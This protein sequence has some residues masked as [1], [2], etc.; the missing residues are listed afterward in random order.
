MHFKPLTLLIFAQ[1][2]LTTSAIFQPE[3]FVSK[4]GKLDVTLEV[5][6][7]TSVNGTRIAPGY[8]GNAMG[9]TIRV[10]P[11]DLVSITLKNNLEPSTS[12]ERE[13]LDYVY[14][15][16]S[17]ILDELN[18]TIAY[19]RLS[20]EGYDGGQPKYGF[21]GKNYMNLHFHGANVDPKIENLSIPL[22][23]GESRTYIFEIPEDQPPVF[24]WYHNHVH[25]ITEYSSLSGLAGAFII[26]GTDEDIT[27][28]PEIAD[29][30]EVILSLSESK[31]DETGKPNSSGIGI[32]MDFEYEYVTNG[33]LGEASTINFTKG[34]TVLFRTI[35]SS[36]RPPKI[37]SIDDHTILPVAFDGYPVPALEET[38][39]IGVHA[40]SRAEFM[41]TFDKPGTYNMHIDAFNLGIAGPVCN[42]AFGIPLDTCISYDKPGVALT[43]IVDD[44]EEGISYSG[45]PQRLPTYHHSLQKLAGMPSLKTR[46]IVF[47]ITHEFPILNIPYDESAIIPYPAQG[48]GMNGRVFTPNYVHGEIE[49]GTCETWIVKSQGPPIAHTFHV[50]SVPFLVTNVDGINQE[51]PFWRD[52]FPVQVNA[53]VHICFPR[54]DGDILAHCHMPAHL[55]KGMAGIYKVVAPP[56]NEFEVE[57]D[58][59]EKVGDT[60]DHQAGPLEDKETRASDEDEVDDAKEELTS[61][62]KDNFISLVKLALLMTWT[63]FH[64]N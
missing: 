14:N 1:S 21:W 38:N 28:I 58:E 60:E 26:E 9:P 22:D 33:E 37:L 42:I 5:D 4:D 53:T 6:W 25:M 57:I 32:V 49:L 16:D 27:N 34:E 13:L 55:E 46:E 63:I 31:V 43:I 61:G 30:T 48:L 10:K 35:G 47:T 62:S 2:F 20:R 19:N 59:S 8:N 11:G 18:V 3:E 40:G 56:E 36:S 12:Q 29:A 45:F 15:P 51:I 24:A 41:V 52:T 23:G 44:S 54:H 7:V 50:H 39:K 17:E 64:I